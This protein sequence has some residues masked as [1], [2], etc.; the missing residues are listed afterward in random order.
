[1]DLYEVSNRQYRSCMGWLKPCTKPASQDINDPAKDNFPVTDVTGEQALVF[2]NWIGRRLPTFAEW[3]RAALG[4]NY[5]TWPWSDKHPGEQ[6]DPQFVNVLIAKFQNVAIGPVAVDDERYRYGAT[7]EGIMHLVGNVWEWSAIP[8]SCQNDLYCSTPVTQ[9]T[10][11]T[12]SYYVRGFG[13]QTTLPEVSAANLSPL[14]EAIPFSSVY[15]A[16][17]E[18]GFRCASS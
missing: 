11:A 6:P 16:N 8:A 13:F 17:P 14:S 3:E 15:E 1:M 5:R 7:D 9:Q 18:F 12:A 2:C 4:L 10:T